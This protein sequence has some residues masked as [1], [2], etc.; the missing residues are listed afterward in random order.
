M[1]EPIRDAFRDA[2][3]RAETAVAAGTAPTNADD[4][5]YDG[6]IE[7]GAA[8]GDKDHVDVETDT[9]VGKDGKPSAAVKAEKDDEDAPAESE[10]SA[11]FVS[12]AEFKAMQAKHGDDPA[13]LRKDLLRVFTQKT[14]KLSEDRKTT[15]RLQEY[16]PIIDAFEADAEATIRALAEQYGVAI[17]PAG[18]SKDAKATATETSK[19]IEAERATLLAEFKDSL[20]PELEYLADHLMPAFEKLLDRRLGPA[21]EQVVKPLRDQN[22]TIVNR[23]AKE[24]TDSIL[25]SMKAKYADWDTHQDAM[26]AL[27]QQLQPGK[28]MT[29]VQYLDHLYRIATRDAWDKA[30]DSTLQTEVGKQVKAALEKMAKGAGG[31]TGRGTTAVPDAQVKQRPAGPVSFRQAAKDAAAGV[32][33]AD[34]DE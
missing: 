4:D 2:F 11:E 20:G 24:E 18:E 34:D 8:A 9:D 22:Q 25:G 3:T 30:K 1:P 31:S 29:E 32:Q 27:S 33:Y 13:A 16:A 28:G 6:D 21:V 10:T 17:A 19:A 12:D 23:V 5:D 15:A 7:A 14:Q 26:F